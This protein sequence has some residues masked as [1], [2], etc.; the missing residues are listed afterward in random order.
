VLAAMHEAVAPA[1]SAHA[2]APLTVPTR[3]FGKSGTRVST[4]S[5]GGMFDIAANQILL[6]QALKWGVTYWD[7]ADCY[8]SGSESGIG[9]YFARY[10]QDRKKVFLVTKSCDRDPEGLSTLLDRSLERMNT[11]YID[12]YFVH[13]VRRI[14]EL[15]DDT[16]RWAKRPRRRAKFVFSV[17]APTATWKPCCHRHPGWGISTGL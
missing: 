10:P 13:G 1:R 12:L 8:M 14:S 2:A 5:L 3:P 11:S 6:R 9:K 7:T 4:L 16:R 15:N 17:S